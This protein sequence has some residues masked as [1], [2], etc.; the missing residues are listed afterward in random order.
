MTTPTNALQTLGKP[1]WL[2]GFNNLFRNE[3]ELRWGRYRWVIPTLVWLAILNGLVMLNALGV[4]HSSSVPP[5]DLVPMSLGLFTDLAMIATSIGIVIV[6]QGVII[7]EKQLGTA[8]WVLSKPASRSA[9]ILAK[10][11]A[12]SLSFLVMSLV[13]PSLLFLVQCKLLWNQLPAPAQFLAGWPLILLHQQFYLTLTLML[14]TLFRSRGPVTGLALGF[15]FSGSLLEKLLPH[16]V[17][18]VTPWTLP[19]LANAL[20]LG[21]VPPAHE[22]TPVVATLFWILIFLGIAL[23]RFDREEF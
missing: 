21:R 20:M 23:W 1:G 19:S 3:N 15:L 12:Y 22:S 4:S 6:V 7:R 17:S 10:W 14:G 18:E 11:S 2:G 5:A 8:A 13:I 9:F 16:W